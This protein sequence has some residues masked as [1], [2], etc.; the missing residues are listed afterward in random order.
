MKIFYEESK[1]EDGKPSV[2]LV[3]DREYIGTIWGTVDQVVDDFDKRHGIINVRN[4]KKRLIAILWNTQMKYP[5]NWTEL[6]AAA[7][8]ALGEDLLDI[9]AQLY[10]QALEK[11]LKAAQ[12]NVLDLE[13][14][15]VPNQGKAYWAGV[16]SGLQSA[17][18]LVEEVGQDE[19][20]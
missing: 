12:R 7:R 11:E 4:D 20:R 5:D 17:I 9:G 3:Y 6:K 2:H 18:N 14:A 1:T 10:A 13:A 19:S 15:A 8:R 16:I